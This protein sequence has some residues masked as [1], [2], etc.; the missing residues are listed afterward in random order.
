MFGSQDNTSSI[1]AY[2]GMSWSYKLSPSMDINVLHA[3]RSIPIVNPLNSQK[4]KSHHDQSLVM[5]IPLLQF[6]INVHDHLFLIFFLLP[7]HMN[8]FVTIYKEYCQVIFWIE[9]PSFLNPKS[10]K[11]FQ[12]SLYIPPLHVTF[13]KIIGIV[14]M[15][16]DLQATFTLSGPFFPIKNVPCDSTF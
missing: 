9:A 8:D 13:F 3:Q 1:I 5:A 11:L 4:N 12:C 16:Q 15:Q 10:L 2:F 14:I 6:S 7:N